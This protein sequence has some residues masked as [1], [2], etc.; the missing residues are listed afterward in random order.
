M[1]PGKKPS[2]PRQHGQT[3][4][5]FALG[6]AAVIAMVGLLID[7][8]NAYA[9]QR[10]TQNG[11]DAAAEAG[12]TT[13]ARSLF[14]AAAGAAQ[15][16]AQL[17]ASVLAAINQAADDNRIRRFD[18]G[19]AGNS[20]AYYTD[21]EG[22][23]LT[24]GGVTTTDLA[25]AAAVGGGTVP[26]C[27]TNCISG[28]AVGVRALA[29]R[30][31]SPFIAGAVGFGQ[32]T[33]TADAT[34]VTGYA[35]SSNCTAA[36][37]C[38]LLPITFATH[39]ATCDNSGDAVYDPSE[40]GLPVGTP[41][42]GSNESI[43][44]TCKNAPGAVG[45]LDFGCGTLASQILNPCNDSISFPLW[46]KAQPGNPNN[47]E[48]QLNTYAG[49][50]V[51]TYE[52]LSATC[53]QPAGPHSDQTVYVPFFDAICVAKNAPDPNVQPIFPGGQ[54]PGTCPGNSPGGGNNTY[55]RIKYF[56][57]FVLDHAYIQ[58]NNFP[59]CNQAP[60]SPLSG[61]NGSNGCL[62][63]WRSFVTQ[64]PGQIVVNPGP[65]GQGTPLRIQL[66]R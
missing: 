31:F 1:E 17:D 46:V 53:G 63:G 22:N 66:I 33:A 65:G 24:P 4:V 60:G 18:P 56:L 40:W 32:F 64:S 38:A 50:Q 15:T 30:Q 39:P 7:G 16:S 14:A 51:G 49:C 52:A 57:G 62:K 5:L 29:S 13:I 58:G 12:A 47:V 37:G 48:D 36:Q 8:G 61:G 27:A 28:R 34:A 26:G 9:Q 2:H 44:T 54:F 11:A 35:P 6:L 42:T 41:F 3:I 21:A 55:Y 20:R 59:D 10:G 23:M 25:S 43:L 45:W 19:V